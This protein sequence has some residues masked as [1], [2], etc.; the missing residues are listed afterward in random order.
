MLF[1]LADKYEGKN[2]FSGVSFGN[3]IPTKTCI[4]K[5]LW[6]HKGDFYIKWICVCICVRV[7]ANISLL[8]TYT[9]T[10][11]LDN[12]YNINT[13][14][15]QA[16]VVFCFSCSCL[17]S[18]HWEQWIFVEQWKIKLNKNRLLYS[19]HSELAELSFELKLSSYI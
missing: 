1:C 18:Q 11:F 2:L 19:V 12:V 8:T 5:I 16:G 7:S 9:H 13:S 4:S 3:H 15:M 14:S 6:R 10:L 17:G